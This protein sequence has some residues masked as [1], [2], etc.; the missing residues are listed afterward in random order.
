[1]NYKIKRKEIEEAIELS[2]KSEGYLLMITRLNNARLFHTYIM[3][4]FKREDI[5]PSLEEQRNL[6]RKELPA[7]GIEDKKVEPLGEKKL[8]PRY[9]KTVD[10]STTQQ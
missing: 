4:N 10:K 1:M 2:E 6:L 7:S 8:P 9:R 3:L 5:L